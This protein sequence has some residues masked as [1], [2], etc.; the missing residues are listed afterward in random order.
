MYLHVYF[1]NNFTRFR[2]KV[3]TIYTLTA[4]YTVS[5]DENKLKVSNN[6]TAFIGEKSLNIES[7]SYKRYR[8]HEW[9]LPVGTLFYNKMNRIENKII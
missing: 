1:S 2:Y 9:L 3:N 8:T 5:A 4:S 7:L 6:N